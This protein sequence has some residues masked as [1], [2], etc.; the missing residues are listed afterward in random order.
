VGA[1]LLTA[2]LIAGSAPHV[3]GDLARAE[4]R[5]GRLERQRRAEEDKIAAAQAPLVR[6][7]AAVQRLALRPPVLALA[8]PGS[9]DDLIHTHALLTALAPAVAERVAGIR[10]TME[11]TEALRAATQQTMADLIDGDPAKLAAEAADTNAALAALPGPVARPDAPP[12]A[13]TRSAPVYRLPAPGT[14]LIGMGERSAGGAARGLTLATAPGAAVVAPASGRI[15]YAGRFRGYGDI[16]ILDHGRGWTSVL[17]GLAG[18]NV[19][20]GETATA[21]QPIGHMGNAR[22]RLTIELRHD[23]RAVDVAGMAAYR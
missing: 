10:R 4:A 1:I 2:L 17:A 8:A 12:R 13:R 6:L 21:G 3:G 16:V 9:V 11:A 19:A 20:V 5:L 7:L 23:G 18:T 22:P 15:A 14:V